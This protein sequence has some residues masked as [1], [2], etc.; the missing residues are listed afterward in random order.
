[1]TCSVD[2]LLVVAVGVVGEEDDGRRAR[3]R[4]RK[5]GG[6][7]RGR[8]RREEGEAGRGERGRGEGEEGRRGRQREGY[9]GEGRREMER[10]WRRGRGRDGSIKGSTIFTTK[11]TK[12]CQPVQPHPTLLLTSMGVSGHG[13]LNLM[14]LGMRVCHPSRTEGKDLQGRK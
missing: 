9:G 5:E 12:I 6:R 7:G 4:E 1:M 14:C 10:V 3:E 8:E 13:F 11:K 2:L